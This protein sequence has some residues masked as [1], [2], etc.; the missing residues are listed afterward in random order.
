LLLA[1]LL[2]PSVADVRAVI[3]ILAVAGIPA[4]AVNNATL[5]GAF[6]V[7]AVAGVSFC[8]WHP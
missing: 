7:P 4:V 2:I 5:L 6:S 3:A 8:C 1:F